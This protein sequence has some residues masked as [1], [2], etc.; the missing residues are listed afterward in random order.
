M[1][2]L[3]MLQRTIF[4][5]RY[6]PMIDDWFLYYGKG[7]IE[8]YVDRMD[9]SVRPFAGIADTFIFTPMADHMEIMLLVLTLMPVSYTHLDVYKRQCLTRAEHRRRRH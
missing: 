1:F 8:N 3:L 2:V 5:F 7:T 6:F 4:G 9:L